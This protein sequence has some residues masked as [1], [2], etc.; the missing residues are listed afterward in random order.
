MERRVAGRSFMDRRVPGVP[1]P[2]G[3][4]RLGLVSSPEGMERRGLP[5]KSPNDLRT[6]EPGDLSAMGRECRALECPGDVSLEA[7]DCRA[8]EPALIFCAVLS[9]PGAEVVLVVAAVLG[10]TG[11]SAGVA[12]ASHV[13]PDSRSIKSGSP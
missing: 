9:V 3:M 8:E 4:E 12:K 2:E 5:E 7:I 10:V 13:L 6:P 1:S 11:A